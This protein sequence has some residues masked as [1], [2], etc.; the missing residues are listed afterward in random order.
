MHLFYA[1]RVSLTLDLPL[2]RT[3]QT[4]KGQ[5]NIENDA[6][7]GDGDSR[8]PFP[9]Q[10]RCKPTRVQ[11]SL[12]AASCRNWIRALRPLVDDSANKKFR[13]DLN[14]AETAAFIRMFVFGVK[15]EYA[16]SQQPGSPAAANGH[17]D[18]DGWETVG[19]KKKEVRKDGRA[20][21]GPRRNGDSGMM[22]GRKSSVASI[23]NA[24]DNSGMATPDEEPG[25][26]A[27]TRVERV[28]T[29]WAAI[30]TGRADSASL[31]TSAA[32]AAAKEAAAKEAELLRIKEQEAERIRKEKEEARVRAEA[33][34]ISKQ[35]HS[36]APGSPK[37]EPKRVASPAPGATKL[38][39]AAKEPVRAPAQ[40]AA[41]SDGASKPFKGWASV[42]TGATPDPAK[43]GWQT[44]VE[45]K[46]DA[47]KQSTATVTITSETVNGA[48]IDAAVK[49]A[50]PAEQVSQP[51][52]PNKSPA[53]SVENDDMA[54][55][56]KAWSGWAVKNPPPMVDLKAEMEEEAKKAAT[57]VKAVTIDPASSPGVED[58]VEGKKKEGKR[59]KKEKKEK[60]GG[61]GKGTRGVP[62]PQR[63]KNAQ[64]AQGAN[65]S[66]RPPLLPRPRRSRPPTAW[67]RRRGRSRRL[68]RP[69][70]SP[71]RRPRE[72][73]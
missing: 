10:V 31:P 35:A 11:G 67:A 19:P 44:L 52:S 50:P 68:P 30:L 34:R 43:E 66:P 60:D 13:L 29:G 56:K 51:Q 21:S 33:E 25:S 3:T 36:E 9:A 32:E 6:W 23:S 46:L 59:E 1:N 72:R 22:G 65:A 45:G 47:E 73:S 5:M 49:K 63:G 55:L 40:A 16:A 18:A 48:P 71:W 27:A 57:N 28:P 14:P 7:K 70:A 69:P 41:S 17:H 2:S 4:S 8:S 20:S 37:T 64:N 24:G 38:T 15:A 58:G 39:A 53:S 61:D 42:V 62:Q 12:S 54:P 26:P